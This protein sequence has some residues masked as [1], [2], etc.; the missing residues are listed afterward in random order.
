VVGRSGGQ[1][2]VAKGDGDSG[3]SW[4]E[5]VVVVTG[6]NLAAEQRSQTA[7]GDDGASSRSGASASYWCCLAE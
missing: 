5:S 1:R 6:S 3:N 4:L 2:M 7:V